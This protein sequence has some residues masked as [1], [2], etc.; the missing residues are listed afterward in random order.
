VDTGLHHY[1]WTRQQVLDFMYAN[2]AVKPARAESEAER[3]MAIPGQALGYKIGQ[4]EI[5]R[6]RELAA[7]RLGPDFDI[8]DFHAVVLDSTALPM[9]VL[10]EQVDRWLET[11]TRRAVAP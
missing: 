5:L 6:L 10:E 4:L 9:A 1:G 8:R 2:T 11:A 7:D 3:Y